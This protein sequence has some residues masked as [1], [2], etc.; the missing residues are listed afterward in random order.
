G[1]MKLLVSAD[2]QVLSST[3]YTKIADDTTYLSQTVDE[4]KSKTPAQLKAYYEKYKDAFYDELG[5]FLIKDEMKKE[6]EKQKIKNIHDDF[7]VF[8]GISLDSLP[9]HISYDAVVNATD[10]NSYLLLGGVFA[11]QIESS[12]KIIKLVFDKNA[13]HSLSTGNGSSYPDP[14]TNTQVDNSTSQEKV[15]IAGT[16][17]E[18][19]DIPWSSVGTGNYGVVQIGLYTSVYHMIPDAQKYYTARAMQLIPFYVPVKILPPPPTAK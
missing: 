17:I 7:Q 1:R 8:P 11:N 13:L 19:S 2:N 12:P 9:P 16:Y 4:W 14:S 18:D 6:L 3:N 5:S 10:G 15:Q